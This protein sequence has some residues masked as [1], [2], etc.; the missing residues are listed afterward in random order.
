MVCGDHRRTWR[1]TELRP[2]SIRSEFGSH[3]WA[4]IGDLNVMSDQSTSIQTE[5]SRVASGRLRQVVAL[6]LFL[7]VGLVFA[8]PCLCAEGA[9]RG[10]FTMLVLLLG[11]SRLAWS[12]YRRTFR[13]RDYFVYL[14]IVIVF[15]LWAELRQTHG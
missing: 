5:V 6:G 9:A 13:Y 15:S 12:V 10:A 8:A 1:C 2:C 11:F 3:K 4:A 7:V 14:I